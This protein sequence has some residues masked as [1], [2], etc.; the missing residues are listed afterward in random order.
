[1]GVREI[2]IEL[3]VV[4]LVKPPV[5]AATIVR[6]MG[7]LAEKAIRRQ[8]PMKRPQMF[9]CSIDRIMTVPTREMTIMSA[10]QYVRVLVRY[11]LPPVAPRT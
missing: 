5:L 9:E 11:V 7:K 10:I 2:T 4:F 3:T 8:Y 1:M 6:D